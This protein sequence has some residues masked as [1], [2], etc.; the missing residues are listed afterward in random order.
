MLSR[1]MVSDIRISTAFPRAGR[2]IST[3]WIQ[4]TQIWQR[5]LC[6]RNDEV[7]RLFDF[8]GYQI[9]QLGRRG[10]RYDATGA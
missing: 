6:D 5:Y 1:R 7:Y 10:P 9:D 3:S 2:V 8:D 4:G